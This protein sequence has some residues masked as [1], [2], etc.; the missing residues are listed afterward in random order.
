MEGKVQ[1]GT[2]LVGM[3]ALHTGSVELA[4]PK[5]HLSKVGCCPAYSGSNLAWKKRRYLGS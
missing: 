5:P 4:G 1:T 2:Q 3:M